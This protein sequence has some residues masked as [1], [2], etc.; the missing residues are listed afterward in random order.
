MSSFESYLHKAIAAGVGAADL[1]CKKLGTLLDACAKHGEET[2]DKGRALNEELHR[3][4]R[5]AAAAASEAS[6]APAE[7]VDLDAMTQE[8]RDALLQRLLDRQEKKDG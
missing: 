3:K 6:E 2:L 1:G 7:T 5:E 4:C 8:E